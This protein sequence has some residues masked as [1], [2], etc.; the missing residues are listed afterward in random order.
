MRHQEPNVKKF[1]SEQVNSDSAPL[2]AMKTKDCFSL[3]IV[4]ALFTT[5]AYSESLNTSQ[6]EHPF[7]SAN[8]STQSVE[9]VEARNGAE[10]GGDDHSATLNLPAPVPQL[11]ELAGDPSTAGY[12]GGQAFGGSLNFQNGSLYRTLRLFHTHRSTSGAPGRSA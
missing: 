1:T 8:E 7:A 2:H 3:P 10:T 4:Q 11:A 5:G 6:L 9:S 12:A